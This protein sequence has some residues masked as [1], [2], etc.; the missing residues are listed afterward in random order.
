MYFG[1][2]KMEKSYSHSER[3]GLLPSILKAPTFPQS[4]SATAY[5]YGK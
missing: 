4:N 1:E 5:L 2:I 3:L